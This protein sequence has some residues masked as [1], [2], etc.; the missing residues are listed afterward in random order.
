MAIPPCPGLGVVFPMPVFTE[1]F[2]Q[3]VND[4]DSISCEVD[5]FTLTAKVYRDDCSD[6]PWERDDGHGPVS[7][8]TRREKRPG[9]RVLSS[10]HSAYRYYD[11][12]DAVKTALADGW[13]VAGGRHKG[14]RKRA[15]ATRAAEHDFA[16]LKAWCD[17]EWWYVGVAVTVARGGFE[18]TPDFQFALWGV[19]CNY[20]GSDNS[21]L[22]EVAE[23]L[24]GDALAVARAKLSALCGLLGES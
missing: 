4:G 11:F 21:Y 18:F 24:A 13:G 22:G 6:A 19:E 1:E 2:G 9:E 16:V 20:P 23:D 5:G 17:D 14:E 15:Y 10:D 8:W 12:E 3:Y 7:G